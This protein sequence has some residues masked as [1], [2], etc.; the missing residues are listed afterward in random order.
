MGEARCLP[1]K[2]ACRTPEPHPS[3]GG[4]GGAASPHP[5]FPSEKTRLT[6]HLRGSGA[7]GCFAAHPYYRP[8]FNLP[9]GG[10]S[11][12]GFFLWKN[13]LLTLITA[14]PL[15]VLRGAGGV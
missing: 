1:H 4:V 6:P 12:L 2:P 13:G 15:G 3:L 14:P 7:G 10:G 5:V 8:L 11:S 9:H